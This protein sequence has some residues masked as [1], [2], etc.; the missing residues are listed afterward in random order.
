MGE[1]PARK[2]MDVDLGQ[3]A[4]EE[5]EERNGGKRK[6]GR[7]EGKGAGPPPTNRWR[8]PSELRGRG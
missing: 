7:E 6:R 5:R 8:R 4:Q 1:Q 3:P 2:V